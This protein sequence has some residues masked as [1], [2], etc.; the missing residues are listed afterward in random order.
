MQKVIVRTLWGAFASLALLASA[1]TFAETMSYEHWG[2]YDADNTTPVDHAPMES[3][4]KFITVPNVGKTTYA[5]DRL[6][7]KPLEFVTQ[8]RSF[9]EQLPISTLNKNEQLAIWLN[10]HNVR[11]IEK[12]AR[13]FNERGKM[14]KHRGKPGAPGDWWQEKSLIVEGIP[15]SLEDIEQ[16]ILLNHWE[17]PKVIYGLFYGVKGSAFEGAQGFSGAT[18]DRQLTT[19]AKKFV[20]SRRNVKIKKNRLEL[21]SLYM[22]NK[23][24]LFEND[25]ALVSHLK[26]YANS[27][28]NR[29]LDNVSEVRA[30]HK[31][32]WAT[33]AY[34]VPRINDS[35]SGA[36]GGGGGYAGGS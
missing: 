11:V 32:S 29:A 31:F 8:Y 5:Y 1:L 22:W 34:V 4:L 25:D 12:I 30:K 20:N 21:S 18:V 23:E 6:K 2:K 27:G 24:Q 35:F 17:D 9:L 14:K 28:L 33:N 16:N 19:L 36:G 15:V 26:T 13:H 10:L 7:G 3:I